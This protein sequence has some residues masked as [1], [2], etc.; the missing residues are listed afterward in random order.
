MRQLL[1]VLSIWFVSPV[2]AQLPQTLVTSRSIVVMDLPLTRDGEYLS[3]GDWQEE[4]NT[5]QKNLNVM[6][7]DAIAYLHANDWEASSTTKAAFQS[8][9]QKREVLHLLI[10]SKNENNLF[11]LNVLNFETLASQWKTTGGSLN[12]VLFRLGKEIKMEGFVVENF[13]SSTSPEFFADVPVSKWTAS[14]S[15]PDQIKRLKI[16]VAQFDNEVQN[17]RLRESLESYPFKYELITYVNDEDAFRKGYQFILVHMG[18]AG[19]S[20]KKLLNYRTGINETDYIS[21]VAADSTSTRLKTIPVDAHVYK[22]YFRQTIT[23]EAYVGRQW[24]A[25]VTWEKSL[26]NFILNLRVAFR[27]L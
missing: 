13:L 18:T 7:V 8:F 21:T 4:A 22:F 5:V 10:L 19:E 16:G 2:K 23:H 25:D 24:D 9:F 6:G 26:A 12:Q 1:L 17:N 11:E 20:I 15:F 3:R 14:T 27:K